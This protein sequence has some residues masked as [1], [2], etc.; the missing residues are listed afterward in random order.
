[1][2]DADI[3][4]ISFLWEYPVCDIMDILLKAD[5]KSIEFWAETPFSGWT[6]MMRSLLLI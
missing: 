6:G 1:V 3:M 4:L 5:I 2:A